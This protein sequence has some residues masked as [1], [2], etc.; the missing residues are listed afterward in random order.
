V[1][2]G[3]G[4]FSLELVFGDT[5]PL[6]ALPFYI[7]YISSR[8]RDPAELATGYAAAPDRTGACEMARQGPRRKKM[9]GGRLR[10]LPP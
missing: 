8:Y 4:S 6:E 9:E 10:L 7:D 3:D 1:F 2:K 5:P